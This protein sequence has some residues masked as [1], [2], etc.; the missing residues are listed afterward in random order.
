MNESEHFREKEAL[1]REIRYLRHYGNRDC[2]A[3]ADEA[4]GKGKLEGEAV[5]A[6]FAPRPP[7]RQ[8][9]HAGCTKPAVDMHGVS[10]VTH[11]FC[12]EHRTCDR[13]GQWVGDCRCPQGVLERPYI[14]DLFAI[15][16]KATE[17]GVLGESA[18]PLSR[19]H[20]TPDGL[21]SNEPFRAGDT[22]RHITLGK[23]RVLGYAAPGE[24]RVQFEIGGEKTLLLRFNA[25][26]IS[27]DL[28]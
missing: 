11:G 19:P 21:T 16:D 6:A 4:M 27:K 15:V 5:A 2:T 12:L 26:R 17:E 1:R 7:V 8:C 28:P 20:L 3:M 14:R 9:C 24:M 18:V 25:D 23:G 10:T 22:I 13:C